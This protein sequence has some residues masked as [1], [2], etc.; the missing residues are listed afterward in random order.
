MLV[1]LLRGPGFTGS[2]RVVPRANLRP[3]PMRAGAFV[4]LKKQRSQYPAKRVPVNPG[5]GPD[6]ELSYT[7]P[8][9]EIRWRPL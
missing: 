8:W 5:N 6:R 9:Q 4:I 7:C 3:V 1:S 2:I